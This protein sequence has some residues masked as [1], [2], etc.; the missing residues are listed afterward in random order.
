MPSGANWRNWARRARRWA[1]NLV[2]RFRGAER[3]PAGPE[4]DRR[5][6]PSLAESAAS[7]VRPPENEL[8]LERSASAE[9]SRVPAETA[10]PEAGSL[11]D[12]T[13]VPEPEAPP[14]P[15]PTAQ[16]EPEPPRE[17]EQE[18]PATAP[19]TPRR[20]EVAEA[21]EADIAPPEES[22]VER[23][24]SLLGQGKVDAALALLED[25][26]RHRAGEWTE[27]ARGLW[28]KI[29]PHARLAGFRSATRLATLE[30]PSRLDAVGMDRTGTK[31][32]AGGL[33][34]HVWLWDV[35]AAE[36]AADLGEQRARITG[37]AVSDDGSRAVASL[38]DG[39]IRHW[40]LR[41]GQM[42]LWD[43]HASVVSAVDLDRD[44]IVA[45]SG[46]Q[47]QTVRVW[48]TATGHCLLVLLGHR[49]QV[50]A[51]ALAR[52][53]DLGISGDLGGQVRI[54]ET[55]SGDCVGEFGDHAAP[56]AAV[57]IDSE[58]RLA[59]SADAAG[60]IRTWELDTGRCAGFLRDAGAGVVWVGILGDGDWVC[61]GNAAGRI[62]LWQLSTGMRQSVGDSV[63][64]P[65]AAATASAD[66]CRIV[67]A[68]VDGRLT[69]WELEWEL[70]AREA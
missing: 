19:Q 61:W 64:G 52:T 53:G 13:P 25:L 39:T 41:T 17:Q 21:R 7:I 23:A 32:V 51:V 55:G 14:A 34:R 4:A 62:G 12:V 57:A 44:G 48:S 22:P 20:D 65:L 8:S 67:C 5:T 37:V 59:V 9:P 2:D 54:W 50:S 10:L 1:Q 38:A 30:L 6:V 31:V 3:P 56:V 35:D 49:R 43:G 40:N 15:Q 47:D 69:C 63:A 46:S 26:R 27:E 58:A 45:L 60:M 68:S 24:R 33:A 11:A 36:P 18:R 70:A 16:P 42:S 28:R 66:G 29:T